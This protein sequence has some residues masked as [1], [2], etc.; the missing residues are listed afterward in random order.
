MPL[1]HW[2]FISNSNTRK[3]IYYAYFHSVIKY[4]IFFWVISSNSGKIFTVQNKIVM[5]MV[6]A[7]PRTFFRS[8][9]KQLEILPVQCQ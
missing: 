3:S 9:F 1:G 2:S 6:G 8:L 5:I 7:Q 4:E